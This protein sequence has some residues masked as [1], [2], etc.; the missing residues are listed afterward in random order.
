MA[1][2]ARQTGHEGQARRARHAPSVKRFMGFADV[3]DAVRPAP[4]EALIGILCQ[5]AQAAK[6]RLV[7]DLGC[8]TG[9]STRLWAGRAHRIIG[10]EPSPDMRREAK[11]QTTARNISYRA[12]FSHQTGLRDGCADIV[13]CSQSFHWMEPASTLAEAARLLR[14]GGVFATIDADW[15]PVTSYWEVEAAYEALR[16][17]VARIRK[18]RTFEAEPKRWPKEQHLKRIR[19]CG[20]FRYVREFLVNNEEPG[21]A[22]RLVGLARSQGSLADLLKLEMTEAEIGLDQLRAVAQRVLGAAPQ[23]WR[24]SYRVRIGIV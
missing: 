4:P 16:S 2:T 3:Y 17:R 12:G 9:L 6:P 7:V 24:F 18:T 5:Y 23:P 13:T 1:S 8:G 22:E 10:I 11:R 20:L 14:H 15:P 21:D 19:S